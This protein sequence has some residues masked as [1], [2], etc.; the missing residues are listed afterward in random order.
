[1]ETIILSIYIICSL[2]TIPVIT[3]GENKRIIEKIKN[4]YHSYNN[5]YGFDSR[6][7]YPY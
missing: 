7:G 2:T 6:F 3:I 5:G 4:I 1:M